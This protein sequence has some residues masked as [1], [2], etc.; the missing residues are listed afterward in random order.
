VSRRQAGGLPR[1]V[2]RQ[3]VSADVSRLPAYVGLAI[4]D[5]GYV[6]LRISKVVEPDPK[7]AT[8]TREAAELF[9]NAQYRAFLA[10]LREHGD[11]EIRKPIPEKK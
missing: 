4:P 10:S 11:I 9:G 2:L 6:L 3:V 5:S 8:D 1:E 7:Q